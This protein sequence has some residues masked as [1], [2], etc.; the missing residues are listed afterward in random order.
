M[1]EDGPVKLN[2]ETLEASLSQIEYLKGIKKDQMTNLCKMLDGKL[3]A[4]DLEECEKLFK[5]LDTEEKNEM[6]VSQLGTVLRI[7][8]Q[9]PT[10]NE[11]AILIETINPKKPENAEK[12]E[13]KKPDKKDKKGK[14][15][16]DKEE[17]ETIDFFKFMLA[18]GLYMRDPV[19]IANDIKK[20]FKVLDRSKQGYI[21]AADLREFLS[22]LG[23]CLLDDE[24]DEMIKL[25]DTESNGQIHYEAFVDLMT[26]MKPG[27]KKGKKGKKKKKKK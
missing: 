14:D 15:G 18:L 17:I 22:K 16:K 12:K 5:S 27:K 23:D 20:A 25:A 1:A 11:L 8:Q 10:D 13:E 7:L 4:E 2:K 6:P 24:V 9:I 3:S 19:E 21:M 26:N